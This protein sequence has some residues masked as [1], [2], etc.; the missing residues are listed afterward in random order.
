MKGDRAT[1]SA[2]PAG[3]EEIRHAELQQVPVVIPVIERLALGMCA[4]S[5]DKFYLV[6][7]KCTSLVVSWSSICVRGRNRQDKNAL[8]PVGSLV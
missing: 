5:P 2:H 7:P 6:L 1:V 8:T 3:F 4:I